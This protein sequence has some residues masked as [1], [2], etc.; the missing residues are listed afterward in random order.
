MGGKEKIWVIERFYEV[1]L[2]A[3]SQ[4]GVCLVRQL[5]PELRQVEQPYDFRRHAVGILYMLLGV[6]LAVFGWIFFFEPRLI[7]V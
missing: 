3:S 6:V 4:Q 2:R 7:L 1:V 5:L